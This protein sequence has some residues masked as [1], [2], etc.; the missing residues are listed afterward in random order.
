MRVGGCG[1]FAY[2]SVKL[3]LLAN[4]GSYEVDSNAFLLNGKVLYPFRG[5]PFSNFDLFLTRTFAFVSCGRPRKQ[6]SWQRD[7]LL[8]VFNRIQTAVYRYSYC[9]SFSAS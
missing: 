6:F 4:S 5:L 2:D 9:I 7:R 3:V 8:F 1:G